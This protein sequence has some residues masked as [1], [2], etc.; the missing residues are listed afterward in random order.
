[1]S[2]DGK[3]P[4]NQ[5]DVSDFGDNGGLL[6][7]NPVYEEQLLDSIDI[8][9]TDPKET[10]D[11]SCRVGSGYAGVVSRI[12]LDGFE[13]AQKRAIRATDM[14][15]LV[16]ISATRALVSLSHGLN[17]LCRQG[18]NA[19]TT[20]VPREKKYIFL[21]AKPLL[22]FKPS[23]PEYE[24]YIRTTMLSAYID[25]PSLKDDQ[26]PPPNETEAL[27]VRALRASGLIDTSEIE[28]DIFYVDKFSGK[29]RLRP[30]NLLVSAEDSSSIALVPI[31]PIAMGPL[32]F[33]R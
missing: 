31:D 12:N 28:P 21:P 23:R 29:V 27:M 5:Y 7:V 33:D 19:F 32:N 1:M 16:G 22:V 2:A 15:G 3:N 25:K 24:I 17:E 20:D 11:S 8:L 26:M 18:T 6:A 13:I 14:D 9:L 10:A 30:G 4:W